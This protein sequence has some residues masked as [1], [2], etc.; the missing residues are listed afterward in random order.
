MD[1]VV[2]GGGI[3]GSS[4]ALELAERGLRVAVCEKG[5]IGQEQSSRNW[6]W[7][8]ITRRDPREV[9]LMAEALRIWKRLDERTGRDTGYRRSGIIFTCSDDKQYAEHERWNRN[10]EGYQLDSRMLSGRELSEMFPNSTLKLKGALY[11]ADDGRAEPQKATPAIAEA[12]RDK[13]A[14]VLTEC[15]V[16]GIET[17]GGAVSGVVTERGPIRC[18]AV[19]LAGGAWSNLFAG[20]MG[21]DFPQLKVMNSVLRTKPLEGGPEQAI[22]HED[23]AI[24]KRQD[25]GYTIAS[26]HENVVHIVPKSFRYAKAFM[27]ALRAEW[28]SLIFR[29]GFRFLDEARIPSRWSLDEPSP[30][31]YNRVLDPVPSKRLSDRALAAA[32]RAFPVLER[33]EIAQRWAGYID[34]TPDAVPVISPI[35]EVPGF[36]LAS[37]FSG[38]GFG[39]GPAAGRLMADLVT[40]STPIVNPKDFR[41][42]RFRDGS[43]IELISGF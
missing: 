42:N 37:G 26:G 14:H 24:R 2:I 32:R 7:V 43:K 41:F 19:V 10:L 12:A 9:P 35:D 21:I 31:E 3:I 13:G 1:V 5:G 25:G 18:K 15:A 34:V 30:F 38:H 8:R 40:N 20:N 33:A 28:R 16:R 23:F 36:Y 4:T 6:G 29:L 17:S 39:I 11:N 22:W 27:P